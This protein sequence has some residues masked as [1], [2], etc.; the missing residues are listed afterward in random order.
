M[1]RKALAVRRLVRLLVQLSLASFLSTALFTPAFAASADLHDV[2]RIQF[3]LTP[4][5]PDAWI[6]GTGNWS[7]GADWTTG[8]PGAT[9]DAIIYSGGNDL[10]TLNVG[11]TTIN[12]LTLG[13]PA[14]TFTST[15]TDGGVAQ[16][17]TISN[18]LNIGQ[19]GS[20]SFSGGSTI[21]AGA[22]SSNAGSMALI[23]GSKFS[24]TGLYTNSG[25]TDLEGASTLQVNGNAGN[26]GSIFGDINGMG[27]ANILNI[28]GTLTNAPNTS[29]LVLFGGDTATLGGLTNQANAL[30]EMLNGS[31]LQVNGNATNSGTLETIA[32]SKNTL[33][34]TG[35]LTNQFNSA[36]FMVSGAG[37]LATLGG[38]NNSAGGVVDVEGQ[39]ILQ[40]TGNVQ[41][42]GF[43]YTGHE[44]SSGNTLDISSALTNDLQL[45]L[46]GNGDV[47]DVGTLTNNGLVH[48]GTGA[49][50]NVENQPGGISVIGAGTEID[51]LGQFNNVAGGG[52]VLSHLTT[53]DGTLELGNGKNTILTPAGLSITHKS[54]WAMC[55]A[56]VCEVGSASGCALM[57]EGCG[58]LNCRYEQTAGAVTM[59]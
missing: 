19:N 18:A 12:S 9:S 10:V 25:M 7:N 5:I 59:H 28:T 32:S 21:T 24:V 34:I 51:V 11:S 44:G 15:L 20:L 45:Q 41:N 55:A 3:L 23:A 52:S 30:T 26:S 36:L 37:N 29:V 47:V 49:T 6:G 53:L 1:L 50:L 22:S 38:L 17:L 13:G 31:V 48:I 54:D 8:V 46:L 14:N 43:L 39:A 33:N 4:S 16:T 58:M 56:P 42:S 2:D 57:V 27:G 35:T 40:V